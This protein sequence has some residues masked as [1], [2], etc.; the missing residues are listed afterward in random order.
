MLLYVAPH[1]V[2]RNHRQGFALRKVQLLI[3]VVQAARQLHNTGAKQ[4][5]A[6]V[7]AGYRQVGRGGEAEGRAALTN[8]MQL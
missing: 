4:D 5:K 1:P 7:A 2:L 6:R 8:H 3:D